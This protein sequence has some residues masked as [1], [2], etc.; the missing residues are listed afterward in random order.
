VPPGMTQR[1]FPPPWIV[2]EYAE[3]FIVKD[4]TGLE[5]GQNCSDCLF[6]YT[7]ASHKRSQHGA[8]HPVPEG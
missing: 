6:R 7:G 3:S 1:R 2:E 5:S 4:V 8:F